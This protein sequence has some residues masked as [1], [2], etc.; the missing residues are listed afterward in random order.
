MQYSDKPP[1][2]DSLDLMI[3]CSSFPPFVWELK[4][5]VY[6]NRLIAASRDADAIRAAARLYDRAASMRPSQSETT[7][8]KGTP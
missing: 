7:E 2:V 5:V 8:T 1:T 4:E 6:P 3:R